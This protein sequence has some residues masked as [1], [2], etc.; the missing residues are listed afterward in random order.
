M[1]ELNADGID[2]DQTSNLHCL[3]MSLLWDSRLEWVN[4][5]LRAPFKQGKD[6]M[7]SGGDLRN[8]I[9]VVYLFDTVLS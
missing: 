1:S 4:L 7:V 3:P 2:P 5:Q 6:S 9:V 8:K